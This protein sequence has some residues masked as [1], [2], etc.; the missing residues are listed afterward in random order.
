MKRDIP[1][2]YEKFYEGQDLF[3][4]SGRRNNFKRAY[5][6]LL[7]AACSGIP[8]AQNLVGFCFN[9]GIGVKRN[10][11]K[12]L[13]WFRKSAHT[14]RLDETT[15]QNHAVALCNL[16]MM[17]D[18]GKGVKEDQCK[19]FTYYRRAAQLGDIIAQ[20]NLGVQ[21]IVGLGVRPD[22]EKAVYWWKKAAR[23]GDSKAQYNLGKYYLEGIGAKN[24]KRH[25]KTWLQKAAAQGHSLA[26]S[27]LEKLVRGTSPG[28]I[29]RCR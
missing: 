25:A 6:L 27:T 10:L 29:P 22:A 15:H 23:R 13:L 14:K 12:A 5:D 2:A 3:Y 19:A 11:K 8:H 16:A 26:R 1:D 4:G 9:Q 7:A 18:Q 21:Y 28:K 17:Y 24:K 20:A